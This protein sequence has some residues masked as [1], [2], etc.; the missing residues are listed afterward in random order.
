MTGRRA[1]ALVARRE[2]S[3]RIF[4]KSFLIGL[5]V[6][7]FI[8]AMVA[9][10]PTAL[11]FGGDEEYT[12]G[13]TDAAALP[14]AQ[15]AAARAGG[16][17][18]G[19]TIR[20]LP[21]GRAAA[22]LESGEVDA[23]LSARQIRGQEEPD[24][25]LVSV[26]QLANREVRAAEALREADVPP[27]QARRALSP[28]PL[29]VTTVEPVDRAAEERGGFAFFAVLILYGQLIGFGY[30]VAMGIVEEKSSRVVEVL[31]STIRPTHLLA[32]KIIGL[33][34]LGLGQLIVLAV[35]G[36]GIAAAAGAL[37]VDRDVMIAAALALAW[38]IVGY[39][40]YAS[41]FACAGALVPRQE[42]LQSVLT[43]L[44][45]TLLVSFF[46][47]FAVLEDPDGTLATV[48]SFVP[49]A[50]PMTMPP[51]IAL[52]EASAGEIVAAF[53]VTLAAA[54]ALVP[55]AAR[56][57]SGAVLRTGAAMKLRDAW[58]AARA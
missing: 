40:F 13:V 42:E 6:T 48:V 28:P 1:V 52:G 54:A 20:R 43:P 22:A 33:G 7:L 12:V 19:V 16:F 47:S 25:T 23:V 37:E 39:A 24:A 46:I 2:I 17:D 4:E 9:V 44:T 56:I 31:L 53:G 10:L 49:F 38:F 30:F 51:R 26:L 11:G 50:A 55:L 5:G 21:P 57:Y 36:L 45:L 14:V 29:A 27:P 41:A 32:G 8:I 3:E 18:A 34:I 15:A 58:R 35:A